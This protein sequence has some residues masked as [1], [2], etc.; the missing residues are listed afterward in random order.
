MDLGWLVSG[1]GTTRPMSPVQ[2][3]KA[4]GG[5]F[6]LIVSR[7]STSQPSPL[8]STYIDA[9]TY[10]EPRTEYDYLERQSR[11]TDGAR[12]R[13]KK[14]RVRGGRERCFD[15]EGAQPG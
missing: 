12:H 14:S 13:P 1:V 10:G 2:D 9:C 8:Q 7:F 6:R 11:S 4:R 3:C 5:P 15:E